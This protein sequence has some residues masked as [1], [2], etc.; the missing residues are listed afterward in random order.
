MNPQG[1]PRWILSPVRLPVSPLSPCCWGAAC[2]FGHSPEVAD[3]NHSFNHRGYDF[4]SLKG[5]SGP[6]PAYPHGNPFRYTGS[7][8]ICELES[9]GSHEN[10]AVR[11]RSMLQALSQVSLKPLMLSCLISFVKTKGGAPRSFFDS[12]TGPPTSPLVP[13]RATIG[14]PDLFCLPG[15]QTDASRRPRLKECPTPGIPRQ[16]WTVN[17]IMPI[18]RENSALHAGVAILS[19]EL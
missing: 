4:I 18:H 3:C 11:F 6:M 7:D 1:L 8:H 9:A 2:S 13:H 5:R 14:D 12:P 15:V 10:G 19:R 16:R 17:P